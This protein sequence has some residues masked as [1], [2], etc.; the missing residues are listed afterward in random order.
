MRQHTPVLDELVEMSLRLAEPEREL[1]ILGEGNTSAQA[2]EQ[3]FYV[4]ASGTKLCESRPES[5]VQVRIE[6][7]LE[8]LEGPELDDEQM[9]A[10]LGAACVEPGAL[11]PSTETVFHAMLLSHEQVRFV[12]HT[13]PV[14]VNSILCSSKW[15]ELFLRRLFPDEIVVCGHEYVLVPYTDPGL[16]L[17]KA[18]WRGV[19][20]FVERNGGPPRTILIQNHG[21]IA[22]G[23]NPAMVDNITAM[24]D[25]TARIILGACTVGELRGLSEENVRR[26]TTRP[27]ELY[28]QKGLDENV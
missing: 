5:F 13:H 3:S 4:K 7:L 17:A 2:D 11:P 23:E 21:L 25:K 22:A 20:D 24:L 26:I 18:V 9:K 15:R 10:A 19:T 1:V 28:R 16:P 14:A 8:L 6:P 12:G 27:D